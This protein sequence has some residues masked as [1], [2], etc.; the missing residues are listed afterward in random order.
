MCGLPPRLLVGHFVCVRRRFDHLYEELSVRLGRLA[1]RYAIWLRLR[2]VGSDPERLSRRAA[3]D[4]VEREL[5]AVLAERGLALTPRD[6][7]SLRRAVALYDPAVRTPA[8]W[9]AR[10]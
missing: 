2:E 6:A 7:R 1:P 8:E 5:A 9:A 10:L 4:F 3:V